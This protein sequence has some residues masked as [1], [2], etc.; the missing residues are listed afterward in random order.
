LPI[1]IA[2]YKTGMLPAASPTNCCKFCYFATE[3]NDLQKDFHNKHLQMKK[4]A[5]C[6]DAISF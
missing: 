1:N 4:I 3:A 2:A 6:Y 5:P